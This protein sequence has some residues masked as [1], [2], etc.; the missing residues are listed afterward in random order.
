MCVWVSIPQEGSPPLLTSR[1]VNDAPLFFS[2]VFVYG[3][4][5]N[6]EYPHCSTVIADTW[7]CAKECSNPNYPTT[8][9]RDL[10]TGPDGFPVGVGGLDS[11]ERI[12][13]AMVSGMGPLTATFTV[14][15]DFTTYESG[16][17]SH[18]RTLAF[19]GVV[20]RCL[21]FGP[22]KSKPTMDSCSKHPP[23]C[24]SPSNTATI[25]R[26][27]LIV[28]NREERGTWKSWVKAQGGWGM[29]M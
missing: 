3:R 21:S 24:I 4:Q 22:I 7:S 9:T 26:D 14:Y 5:P 28:Y 25:D 29:M 12:Q 10:T 19:N 15:E 11:V 17:Y 2:Y 20:N 8:Y 27:E 1:L 23:I 18:V 6:D 13:S 16:I